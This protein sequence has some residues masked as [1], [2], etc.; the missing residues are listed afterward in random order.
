MNVSANSNRVTIDGNIKSMGDFQSIKNTIDSVVTTHKS[1][2]VDVRDSLSFTSV[3]IGY[4]NKLILK[5]KINVQVNVGDRQL[6]DL[7]DEL[8]LASVF[9][10]KRI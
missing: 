6:Y 8:N 2:V 7:L 9:K 10:L 4:F 5:D 3:T 1:I